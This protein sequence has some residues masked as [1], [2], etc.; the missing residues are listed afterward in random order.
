MDENSRELS[1]ELSNRALR[2]VRCFSQLLGPHAPLGA[3][4]AVGG[5]GG[6]QA[7]DVAAAAFSVRAR[8]PALSVADLV[9]EV[10][11][12]R[13]LVLTWTMRGTRHLHPAADVGWLLQ[14]FG[15]VFGQAGRR[16]A[17]LGIAGEVGDR[18]QTA[19]RRALEK[20]ATPT[21]SQLK[22]VLAAAGVD[23]T[24]QAHI[25]AIRRAA[26]AGVLCVLPDP[27]GGPQS[28]PGAEER[29]AALDAWIG[30]TE[31]TPRAEALARLGR[32]FLHSYGPATPADLRAWSGLPAGD[33]SDA[34]A[35]A[36]AL[37]EVRGPAGPLWMLD[38]RQ[39]KPLAPGAGPGSD[40]GSDPG[41]AHGSA[42]GAEPGPVRLVGGFDA[43][44]LGYADRSAH[45]APEHAGQVNAGGGLIRPVA[46]DDGVV[47]G[48]WR[49]RRGRPGVPA[50]D[51]VEVALFAPPGRRL[52]RDLE[53]E[54]TAVGAFLGTQPRLHVA[55]A[56]QSV[57]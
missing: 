26:L 1:L 11:Q 38:E 7:Q 28:R 51:A 47:V 43:L 2:R 4:E 13:S 39:G 46:L 48:T 34:W 8:S 12:A 9:A 27:H 14:V 18:A 44:L 5:A 56:S 6:I 35:G 30:P 10:H 31:A 54:A 23:P 17:E 24:G 25:H 53:K 16:A 50:G 32:R 15:P 29:Y 42:P 57:G 45:L 40:P 22:A 21:R 20:G 55:G 19:I 37:V 52:L 49:Y 36:G 41:S 33:V 3:P